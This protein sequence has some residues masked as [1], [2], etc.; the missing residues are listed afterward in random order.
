MFLLPLGVINLLKQK[1]DQLQPKLA[2]KIS[3]TIRVTDHL[4]NS[5]LGYQNYGVN[6][7]NIARI[8]TSIQQRK[9]K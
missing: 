4:T 6:C 1:Q 2:Q 8:A 9:K 7:E 5:F 3:R